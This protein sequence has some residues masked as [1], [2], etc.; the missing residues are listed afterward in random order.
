MWKFPWVKKA[1]HN[2]VH[3]RSFTSYN[4]RP[5][6]YDC[7]MSKALVALLALSF[8]L[9]GP[10]TYAQESTS[11]DPF[12]LRAIMFDEDGNATEAGDKDSPEVWGVDTFGS[13]DSTSIQISESKLAAETPTATSSGKE[14][15]NGKAEAATTAGEKAGKKIQGNAQQTESQSETGVD[16][17]DWASKLADSWFKNLKSMEFISKKKWT[18]TRPAQ[19]QFTCHRDGH[20]SGFLIHQSSGNPAYDQMQIEALKRTQPLPPFPEGSK[21]WVRQFVMGWE[22]HPRK[23]GEGDYKP[24]SYGKNMPVERVKTRHKLPPKAGT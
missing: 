9:S 3:I 21:K 16:W 17:S 15:I 13:T 1:Q 2:P 14:P 22:A 18:T 7:R 20:I 23:A 8:A 4:Q 6:G 11:L 19:I 10:A 24:G 12:K 5:F